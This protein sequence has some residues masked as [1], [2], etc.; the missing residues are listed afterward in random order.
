MTDHLI[1]EFSDR[2]QNAKFTQQMDF[3]DMITEYL[4]LLHDQ[5]LTQFLLLFWRRE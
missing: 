1:L 2:I 5:S 3:I 4:P